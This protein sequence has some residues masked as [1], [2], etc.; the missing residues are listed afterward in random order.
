MAAA[1]LVNTT[2]VTISSSAM[3]ESSSR[4][5]QAE[6]TSADGG[7][8][9]QSERTD[10]GQVVGIR[11]GQV[12]G[13]QCVGA[14][15]VIFDGRGGVAEE[16]R[17]HA[18]ALAQRC[19]CRQRRRSC[20]RQLDTGG[21][22]GG[23]A[24]SARAREEVEG[25]GSGEAD[26]RGSTESGGT[27]ARNPRRQRLSATTRRAA[28]QSGAQHSSADSHVGGHTR[29][30]GGLHSR[31]RSQREREGERATSAHNGDRERD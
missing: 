4:S 23:G 17:R 12:G 16:E 26:C 9:Q 29:A 5:E 24:T 10:G 25:R 21:R 18:G 6:Y 20:G 3:R 13:Q 15:M 31:A 28:G 14:V 11:G 8:R 22:R 1:G 19:S 30:R 27:W 2:G 7:Q